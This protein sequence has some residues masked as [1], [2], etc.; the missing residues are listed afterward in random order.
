MKLKPYPVPDRQRWTT[1]VQLLDGTQLHGNSALE[2]LDRWRFVGFFA[3]DHGITREM[4][5]ERTASY[6]RATYNAALIGIG[7][8]TGPDDFLDALA[9]EG[10]IT[11]SRK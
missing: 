8:S 4:F 11:L 9:A 7:A 1:C 5:Q 2:I 6:A 10:V 3:L